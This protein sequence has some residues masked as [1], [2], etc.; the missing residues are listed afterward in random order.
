M[1]SKSKQKI[2]LLASR[3]Q[4]IKNLRDNWKKPFSHSKANIE[5]SKNLYIQE[6]DEIYKQFTVTG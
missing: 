2:N 1:H 4:A 6:N 3:V 5:P